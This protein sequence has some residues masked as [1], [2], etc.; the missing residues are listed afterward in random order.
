LRGPQAP[1]NRL[2]HWLR[3]LCRRNQWKKPGCG[4]TPRDFAHALTP[5]EMGLFDRRKPGIMLRL[6]DRVE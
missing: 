4:A 5:Y 1:E 6:M 3:R 2:F